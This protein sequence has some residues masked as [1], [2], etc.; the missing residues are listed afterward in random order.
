MLNET[1]PV[2][3]SGQQAV[4]ALPEHI[5][6][7]NAGQVR[8]E[9]LSAINRGAKSLIA[10][11]TAT[12]S[13]DQAGTDAVVRAYQRAIVSGTELRLVVA[14]QI[15]RRVLSSNGLGRLVAIYPTLESATAAR[16][17][18]VVPRRPARPAGV[19]SPIGAVVGP[20][21]AGTNFPAE[22][23]PSPVPI[24]VGHTTLAVIR[25]ITGTRRPDDV[26]HHAQAA[27]A[28][29][30]ERRSRELLDT[31]VTTL[32]HVGLSLQAAIEL[33]AEAT[34]QR[35]TDALGR[36]DQTI[37]QIRST[38]FTGRSYQA[39]ARTSQPGHS[40]CGQPPEAG[41]GSGN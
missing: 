18:A 5:D 7:S 14:A 4:M 32:F 16:A 9:L 22:I 11:M 33:P 3:W 38:A 24:A 2:R 40:P 28:A 21:K 10:D 36:L 27:V 17:P 37:S 30:Q 41:E 13:C 15:V 26:A 8:E 20:R 34:R 29:E 31:V 6:V 12:M 1:Y 35:I 39:G 19:S 23:G 25:D